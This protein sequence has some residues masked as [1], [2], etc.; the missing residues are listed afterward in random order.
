MVW[1]VAVRCD[2]V[3]DLPAQCIPY[4]PARSPPCDT[5]QDHAD[6]FGHGVS[7]AIALVALALPAGAARAEGP[8]CSAS[9]KVAYGACYKKSQDRAKCQTQLQR[10]LESCI[11]SKR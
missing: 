8:S 5:P 2:S 11:K 7:L 9:C 6:R 3:P 1:A 4:E 10:C